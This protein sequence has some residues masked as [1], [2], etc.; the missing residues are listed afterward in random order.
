MNACSN[1][2][3]AVVG[4]HVPAGVATR[5]HFLDANSGLS[6]SAEPSWN[7]VALLSVGSPRMKITCGFLT[8]QAATQLTRPWAMTLPTVTL[9]NDT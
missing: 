3:C 4:V 8:F 2:V 5:V 9:L 1:S 7:R 6:T